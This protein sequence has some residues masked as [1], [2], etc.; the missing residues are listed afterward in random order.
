MTEVEVLELLVS[1]AHR[2]AGRPSDGPSP[3]PSDER[4]PR[5]EVRRGL[6]LVGDRYYARPAH[7]NASVTMMASENL[8]ED[9]DLR[10]TRR[11]VLLRGI[12][13][14]SYI[15]TTISL[16]CGGGP[17]EFAVHRPARPCAW[18]DVTIGPG[19][20]RALRGR[21]GVRCTPLSDG[22]LT[23]GPATFH[24]VAGADAVS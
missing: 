13:I 5:A 16:D 17:A 14:D 1:P 4:V 3:G 24:V 8:P 21:G 2:L 15:G 20:Q 9:A 10:H 23:L 7:R 12:D 6:G 22:V 18:M 11:N 19:A